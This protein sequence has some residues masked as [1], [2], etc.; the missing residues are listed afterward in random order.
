MTG[1][2]LT[3]EDGLDMTGK[4]LTVEDGLDMTETFCQFVSWKAWKLTLQ[5]VCG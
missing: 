4:L 3:V 1:K 5:I 2:L